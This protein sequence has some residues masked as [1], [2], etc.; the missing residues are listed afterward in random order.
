[1]YLVKKLFAAIVYAFLFA[2][3]GSILG[4]V[5]GVI[6]IITLII[7]GSFLIELISTGHISADLLV[8]WY[9]STDRNILYFA[10]IS[11]F[12]GIGNF[13]GLFLGCMRALEPRYFD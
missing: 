11:T 9:L 5:V 12:A 10:I 2:L 6:V 1:M 13:S 3:V 8:K 4:T 7:P